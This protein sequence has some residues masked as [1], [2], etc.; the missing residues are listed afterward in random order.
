M[1]SASSPLSPTGEGD[2]GTGTSPVPRKELLAQGPSRP[3]PGSTAVCPG[4]GTPLPS[5]RSRKGSR[6]LLSPL[7]RWPAGGP[8]GGCCSFAAA[9]NLGLLPWR[10]GSL[11]DGKVWPGLVVEEAFPE[12]NGTEAPLSRGRALRWAG[13]VQGTRGR[14]VSRQRASLGRHRPAPPAS[15]ALGVLAVLRA[16]KGLFRAKIRSVRLASSNLDNSMILP[17][18]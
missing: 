14:R 10:H 16:Q 8:A 12:E 18:G 5:L 4:Q 2:G 6:P 7:R 3:P 17:L 15:A 13:C 1:G 9:G 11:N